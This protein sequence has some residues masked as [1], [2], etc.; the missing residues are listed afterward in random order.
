MYFIISVLAVEQ[1]QVHAGESKRSKKRKK[2]ICPWIMRYSNIVVPN[3][4]I[5]KIIF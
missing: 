1:T 5:N 4:E 2:M 3:S